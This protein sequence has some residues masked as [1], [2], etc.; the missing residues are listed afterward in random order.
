MLYIA[1]SIPAVESPV[2]MEFLANTIARESYLSITMYILIIQQ[3]F[4]T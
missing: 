4:F 3:A 2:T 1:V